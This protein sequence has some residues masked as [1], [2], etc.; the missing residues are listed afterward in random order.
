MGRDLGLCG[1]CSMGPVIETASANPA[2]LSITC[3]YPG[4]AL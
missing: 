2:L 4:A 3:W 1:T